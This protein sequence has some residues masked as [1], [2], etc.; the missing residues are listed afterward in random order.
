MR[1]DIA[2]LLTGTAVIERPFDTTD[3]Q[4][5]Y[6]RGYEAIGTVDCRIEPITRFTDKT[7]LVGRPEETKTFFII[8]PAGT[9]IKPPDKVITSGV[10]YEV[11]GV[12][13]PRTDEVTTR[14][15]VT[16]LNLGGTVE[17]R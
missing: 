7:L 1:E 13:S 17:I 11:N 4:G 14:I 2:P 6:E 3:N 15:E 5:G 16:A 10:E 9:D 12:R 8:M